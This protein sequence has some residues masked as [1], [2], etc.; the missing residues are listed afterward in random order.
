MKFRKI[1]I[2]VL[3]FA[4]ITPLM[5]VACKKNKNITVP[6]DEIQQETP[7]PGDEIPMTFTITGSIS[8]DNIVKSQF[9]V[10][11]GGGNSSASGERV[12]E[13]GSNITYVITP[14]YGRG[15][16]SILVDGEEVFSETIHNSLNEF[17]YTF[18]NVVENHTISVVVSEFRRI[19]FDENYSLQKASLVESNVALDASIVSLDGGFVVGREGRV[20]V[21]NIEHADI[22]KILVRHGVSENVIVVSDY[23]E[24]GRKNGFTLSSMLKDGVSGL[25]FAFP[26]WDDD[27]EISVVLEPKKYTVYISKVVDGEFVD[28]IQKTGEV[29]FGVVSEANCIERIFTSNN[30]QT[31]YF[32]TSTDGVSKRR[33]EKFFIEG[34]SIYFPLSGEMLIETSSKFMKIYT[35]Q[36]DVS[37]IDESGNV[38][39]ADISYSS[40]GIS[41]NDIYG[42]TTADIVRFGFASNI[43]Y[44]EGVIAG[45]ETKILSSRVSNGSFV[46]DFNSDMVIENIEGFADRIYIVY[47]KLTPK[48]LVYDNSGSGSFEDRTNDATFELLNEGLKISGIFGE[49][50]L[51]SKI[52]VRGVSSSFNGTQ[53]D[54]FERVSLPNG[55]NSSAILIFWDELDEANDGNIYIVLQQVD[56]GIYLKSGDQYEIQDLAYTIQNGKIRIQRSTAEAFRWGVSDMTFDEGLSFANFSGNIEFDGNY[57]SIDFSEIDILSNSITIVYER[58]SLLVYLRGND[59]ELEF[60][61]YASFA[62]FLVADVSFAVENSSLV[63]GNFF[64]LTDINFENFGISSYTLSNDALSRE[65]NLIDIN[66]ASV[67]D[68][69]VYIIFVGG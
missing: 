58:I 8:D 17:E 25:E 66:N 40:N 50:F 33:I 32:A 67:I 44:N 61:A 51:T 41:L 7:V 24:A 12:V 53:M 64:F 63:G 19:S 3:L 15:I 34:N 65:G 43:E 45:F 31:A 2:V 54:E 9:V 59:G 13:K 11:T 37:L 62:E 22:S 20:F 27:V 28:V 38:L 26:S 6:D 57:V 56:V 1:L 4:C 49:S 30:F 60:L 69:V 55:S 42:V 48:I 10:R 5:F 47:R 68:E 16:C 14:S 23:L 36:V 39:S 29:F 46:L 52:F 18:Y 21:P 35:T